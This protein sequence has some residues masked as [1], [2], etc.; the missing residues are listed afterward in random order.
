M[1]DNMRG[2][3]AMLASAAGFV[4]N[5]ATVKLITAELPNGEI[6]F[7]RGLVATSIMGLVTSILRGWRS[8][9]V[10]AEPAMLLRLSTAALATLFVVAALR[11][12][13]L[14]TTNAIIQVSPL[15]VTAGA[16][17]LLGAHVGWR[18]WAASGAGLLGVLLIIKPG[19]AGF[20]P[21]AWL[22]LAC[23]ACSS[24]R[25]LT[26]RFVSSKVPSIL[27]TFATSAIITLAGL[28]LCPFE[29]W[30]VPSPYALKQIMFTGMALFF[31]Y[32]FGIVA[33]RTG[34]IP[35]VAPFRYSSIVLALLLGYLLWGY[36]PDAVSLCGI[37]L[38]VSAGLFL[39]FTERSSIR[40]T[41]PTA[42][43][44][45]SLANVKASP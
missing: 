22:A 41:Q 18:R 14:P 19:A 38:V 24:T 32:H 34:E 9:R 13:P 6:I 7:L 37:A 3:L 16:A 5:D 1:T 36:V 27:L 12:L 15:V 21:E 28:A 25:D 39:L 40:R 26:T 45:T 2:I 17:L 8:P 29:Q 31:A 35:V 43:P 42:A 11:Y 44:T 23:L 30:I 20:V 10:L 4:A 33:M